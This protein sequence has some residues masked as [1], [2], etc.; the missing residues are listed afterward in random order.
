MTIDKNYYDLSRKLLDELDRGMEEGPELSGAEMLARCAYAGE[1]AAR[2]TALANAQME[3]KRASL[4]PEKAEAFKALVE[5]A[6]DL[7]STLGLNFHV[8]TRNGYQG[9]IRLVGEQLIIDSTW[10]DGERETLSQL[11][12]GSRAQREKRIADRDVL[13][14]QLRRGIIE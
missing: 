2:L 5:K 12:A 6:D 10:D 3:E 1:E 8:R 14:S 13:R 4:S 7:A 9:V 11:I